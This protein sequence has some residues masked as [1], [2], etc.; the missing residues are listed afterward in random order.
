MSFLIKCWWQNQSW[1]NSMRLFF[2][3]WIVVFVG[4]ESCK[5]PS[6]TDG[7]ELFPG[8]DGLSYLQTDTFNIIATTMLEDSI[9]TDDLSLALVGTLDN[10][11]FGTTQCITYTQFRLSA[12]D[13]EIS[14]A[15]VVDSVVLSM[16]YNTTVYG[17]PKEQRFVVRRLISPMYKDSIYSARQTLPTFP[18]NLI[19]EGN[20]EQA[21]HYLAPTVLGE[22][23][24][25]PQL[26]LPLDKEL[27]YLLLQ[28][29][30]PAVLQSQDAFQQYFTGLSISSNAWND[31]VVRY[32]LIDP[33]TGITVYYRDQNGGVEDTLSYQFVVT[34]DCARYNEF[35]HFYSG[36]ELSDFTP[37]T[38]KQGEE[39]FYIQTGAGLKAKLLFPTILNL[40]AYQDQV[41]NRAELIIPIEVNS[42]YT[43]YDQLYLR[44]LGDDGKWKSLPDENVQV[45]GGNYNSTYRQY[46]FNISRYIQSVLTGELA[47]KPLYVLGGTSGVSVKGIKA[48]GPKYNIV[49]PSENTRLVVTFAH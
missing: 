3:F 33:A 15:F 5:K 48:H 43:E 35:R 16:A 14:S 26:R 36:S 37:G 45:I 38:E 9:Y 29:Q 49:N 6:P 24:L 11:V 40:N 8:S 27:G 31:A 41:V 1:H 21:V 22:D 18:D 10:D 19:M 46:T 34:T 17:K 42:E 4:L 28:P 30:D 13:P 32:D 44:Y 23:T 2:W 47:N 12:L 7:G 20:E 39:H 25:S